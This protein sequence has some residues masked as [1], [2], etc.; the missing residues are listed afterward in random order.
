MPGFVAGALSGL[1]G[2]LGFAVDNHPS[3]EALVA[4]CFIHEMKS[5]AFL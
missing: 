5:S 2:R 3:L 1:L 4:E